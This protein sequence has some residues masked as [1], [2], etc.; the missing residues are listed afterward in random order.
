[1]RL[2][3]INNSVYARPKL[4][5][6]F[7][8]LNESE[9]IIENE[10]SDINNVSLDEFPLLTLREKRTGLKELLNLEVVLPVDFEIQASIYLDGLFVIAN[11]YCFYKD[12][13]LPEGK[14]ILPEASDYKLVK[15]GAYILIFPVGM[16]FDTTSVDEGLQSMKSTYQNKSE[17]MIRG[18]KNSVFIRIEIKFADDFFSKGDTVKIQC[19]DLNVLTGQ[20]G[21]FNGQGVF[22]VITEISRNYIVVPGSSGDFNALAPPGKLTITR[23]IPAMDYVCENNNRVWGCSGKKHEI[24][25]CKLGDFKNW[26]SFEQI[27]T[28]SYAATIGTAGNFTGCIAHLGH[29]LFFKENAIHKVFGD[30]P[31]NFQIK[32]YENIGV[33]EGCSNTLS[34]LKETLYYVGIDGV[35]SYDGAMPEKIS[36]KIENEFKGDF[37]APCA[38]KNNGKYYLMLNNKMF[39][40]YQDKGTWIKHDDLYSKVFCSLGTR[41]IFLKGKVFHT[42]NGDNINV[43]REKDMT[44]YLESGNLKEETLA[45]KYIKRLMFHIRLSNQS[46]VDFLIKYDDEGTWEKVYTIDSAEDRSYVIPIIPRRHFKMKYRLEGKGMFKLFAISKNIETGSEVAGNGN[47]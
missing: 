22:K 46:H 41:L 26:Y 34:I 40:Y 11:R 24:Y 10:F 32:S 2:P 37:L 13:Y 21:M 4:I 7:G 14:N 17:V 1:M 30:K 8:G 6:S 23:E 20:F 27:S 31:N 43:E 28:D 18:S 5:S 3:I 16:Y 29:V 44:W 25:A 9:E 15:M 19:S 45:N 42:F 38:N 47:F 36:R 33:K 35:Y 39:I 12:K